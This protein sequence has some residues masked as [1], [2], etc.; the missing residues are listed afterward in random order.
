MTFFILGL[1]TVAFAA[2]FLRRAVRDKD[3]EGV[4]GFTAVFLA[5]LI[6]LIFYGLFF[7]AVF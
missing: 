4:V 5:S 2:Y 1:L 6:L 7:R 3:M